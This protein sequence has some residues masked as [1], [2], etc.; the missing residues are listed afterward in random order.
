MTLIVT[1]LV[2]VAPTKIMQQ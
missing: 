1:I 2:H